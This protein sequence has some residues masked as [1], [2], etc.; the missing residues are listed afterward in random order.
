MVL[1]VLFE[2]CVLA[3]RALNV[4]LL[5]GSRFTITQGGCQSPHGLPLRVIAPVQQLRS[6]PS[7]LMQPLPPQLPQDA[8]QQALPERSPVKHVGSDATVTPDE[9]DVFHHLYIFWHAMRPPHP[10]YM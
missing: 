4:L 3:L 9:I 2:A 10:T 5:C 6:P 8:A 1:R 7:R